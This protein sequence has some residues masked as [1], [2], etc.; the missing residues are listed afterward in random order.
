[1]LIMKNKID[2]FLAWTES[3]AHRTTAVTLTECEAVNHLYIISSA[4]DEE[5]WEVAEHVTVLHADNVTG[6][7]FFRQVAARAKAEYVALYLKPQ[8]LTLGYRC[9]ERLLQAADD[10]GA[11]MVYADHYSI[12]NGEREMSPKIAYQEGSVRD[13]FDFG[14]LLL[15]RASA[16]KSFFELDKV[17]RYR[18]AALYALRLHLSRVGKLFHLNEYLYTEVE[19]DLRKSG[20]KQFDY[21]DPKNREVQLENER[22]CTDHLKRIGAYL[23]PDEFDDLP[24]DDAQYPVEASVIIPVRNRE[25]TIRDAIG[26]VLSQQADFDFNLIVVD[27]HS[28]DGTTEA[29]REFATDKRVVHL[30]PKQTDLGIGGCWD[31]AVRSEHCGRYAVQLDSDDL[32]S[33]A[34]TLAQ[35]VDAFQ[36]QKAAMVIGSYRMVDMNLQTLPPGIIDHKEWTPDNG[37]NNALRI[38]GLGA[39]RAF[40]TSLLRRIGFPNTSYGEDYALG[41]AFSRH[42]RIGRIYDE[43]YLCRRWEGNSDAALSPE[44]VNRNNAYKDRLRTLEIEARRQMNARW[45]HTTTQEEVLD[46]F[47]RQLEMWDETRERVEALHKNVQM[48]VLET[49]DYNLAVQYNPSRIVSTGAKVD[50]KEIKKRPCFLCDK[51]RPV[52]QIGIPVEGKYQVL[53]NPF[54]IL[55]Y[56]LTLPTRRHVPQTLECLLP[57]FGKMAWQMPDFF[58][59]YNGP[60]CG[61]SAPDHAHLQA[62]HRGVVPIER[63][64]KFYETKLEK[65][66]PL[67]PKEEAELDEMGYTSSQAGVYQ[68]HGYA[69]PAFVVKGCQLETDYYL[70]RKLLSAQ[71][72]VL[73]AT[74]Q[75]EPDVN[76]LGWRQEGGPGEGDQ[77]VF[78]VF[79]RKKHRPECYHATGK[80]QFVISPGSIDMGGLIITPREE[81]YLK[82]TPKQA[83]AILSEVSITD[84]E[85]AQIVKR[86]RTKRA[87]SQTEAAKSLVSLHMPEEPMIQVGIMTE[88]KIAFRLNAPYTAKGNTVTGEQIVECR[89]G[90]I[91]WNG[92]VYSELKFKP[93]TDDASF[94]IDNVQIGIDYHWQR[95]EPQ[96]FVGQLRIIVE[97]EKLVV[98]NKLPIEDYLKSVISSEMSATASLELLK[99]HA[100]ISRSWLLAQMQHRERQEGRSGGFFSFQRKG[101]EFIRWYDRE[102]HTLFD[103]CAD[104][105]CQRYQG[106]TRQT[107]PLVEKA[108]EATRAM[109]LVSDGEVCDARFSKCCGGITERYSTCWEDKELSY[110][111]PV[112][113]VPADMKM[114]EQAIGADNFDFDRWIRTSPDAFCNTEDAHLLS[115][116]LNDYDR[117]TQDF[118]RWKVEFTQTEL[119]RLL[120]ERCEED[121]GDILDL[122]PVERGA[123]GRIKKLRIVG[124]KK[125]LVIGK[126][127]EIRRALSDSHLYSSAFSVELCDVNDGIPGRVILYGAGWGHGVGLCQ[128]GAA[129]MAERGYTYDEILLH[130]YKDAQLHK[131]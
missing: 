79:P 33:S 15:I 50:K 17:G 76:I 111:H 131:L 90:G 43:L 28:T 65:V 1:M 7:K 20:E 26:S 83:S 96:T 11:V 120:A 14:G 16:L 82:L 127:L 130:Y 8:A 36:K 58:V 94:T 92:N 44:K 35:I 64:W 47:A 9:L 73:G 68:L 103:V 116:V 45:S 3:E 71:K 67:T 113:D 114:D 42:F 117:E 18:F 115:Q 86:L 52:E 119:A 97:E 57:L 4:R 39:P 122:Q 62:G 40:N 98:I 37:R 75:A 29:I 10:S 129:V 19:S 107:S 77:V 106:I 118:Y 109:V 70:L 46:F 61:A 63:D 80:Q 23:A 81:D 13:D 108:V 101:D 85:A 128:I 84:A 66:F 104:D 88:E 54:P 59:F 2:F 112:H 22:A 123:S 89:D 48:R 72:S 78:V 69:C 5:E 12:K 34:S 55:P 125:Q 102:D 30:I 74:G 99:A 121:F 60:H 49:E 105:H 100:V 27:N 25:R 32:Y 91:H 87:K 31:L 110:L 53:I 38:N 56:H 124:S 51:N 95:T 126:E 41:L 24:H 93:T 6:T 21:V